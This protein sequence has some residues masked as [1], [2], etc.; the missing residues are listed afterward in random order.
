[1]SFAACMIGDMFEELAQGDDLTHVD[2]A[3]LVT[4]ITGWT[5]AEATVAAHRLAAIAELTDR[6]GASEQAVERQFWACDAWDS[7]AAEIAAACGISARVAS[8][9][10]RQGLA[11]RYRLPEIAKLM[12][13]GTLSAR[14]A[15][16][17]GWR[18]QLVDDPDVLAQVDG[19][20]AEIAASFGS[21]SVPKLEAA[22]D[23]V[24]AVHD[25]AAVRR[26]Q[27]A[28]KGCD[29]E[30]GAPDDTT[31]T[32]SMW[33]R[34]TVTDAELFER[35]V[36]QLARSVCPRDPR[37][38]G[39]RRSA[40]LGVLG[41][42]GTDLPCICGRPD[43]TAA[44]RDAR[45][46]AIQIHILTDHYPD[47]GPPADPEPDAG[48]PPDGPRPGPDPEPDA[49]PPDTGSWGTAAEPESD[50][51]PADPE[52]SDRG[53]QPEPEPEPRTEPHSES[54]STRTGLAV[55]AGG[56][57]VPTALLT[58]LIDLGAAVR[59]VPTAAELCA[60]PRYRPSAKL[61]RYVRSR[62]LTCCFPNCDRPAERC[63]LDHTTPHGVGGLTHPGNTK[64]L[65]R[66]HHLLKTFW[67]GAGGWADQQLAD[68]TI[69][70]LSPT[71]HRYTRPP[72]SRLYF[73]HWDTNTPLPKG[74]ATPR[75]ATGSPERGLTM[76]TRKTTRGW[77]RALRLHAER[78]RNQRAIDEDTPPY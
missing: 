9:Q 73:P 4:A 58:E 56:G 3:A 40:A 36:N 33:G 32:T 23:A 69:V 66:K 21:L 77:Q 49:P 37:T 6:R 10:M 51:E 12:S 55:I 13:E 31:G 47:A 52:P 20:L 63:D 67:T 59:P 38:L 60:E 19:D 76:P 65:C 5:R 22:I 35:R 7:A 8:N 26:F 72:G 70:W 28:A 74:S 61:A 68:G 1:M 18:T 53:T 39:E 71:G 14:L 45:A 25:P 30:F 2:D 75:T 17:I 54:R 64:C 43:C 62:D 27:T 48:P 16:T 44:G 46:D 34:L 57:I 41:A 78:Q 50:A 29:V 24:I 42:G 15:N 11:L